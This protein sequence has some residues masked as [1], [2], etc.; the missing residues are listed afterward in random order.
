MKHKEEERH[1]CWL[2]G[3]VKE[4]GDVLR[5]M[6]G[7]LVNWEEG[8]DIPMVRNNLHNEELLSG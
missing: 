3:R 2:P 6:E 5:G 8:R 4:D 1:W 7:T